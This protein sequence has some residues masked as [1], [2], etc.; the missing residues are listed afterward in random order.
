MGF[1]APGALIAGAALLLAVL[2]TYLLRPRRPTRPVSSTF[3]WLAALNDVQ[4][5]RPWRR[6]P[7][8]LLLLLQIAALAAMVAALARPY[9][10]SADST[11]PFSVVLIDASASMQATDTPPTRFDVARTRVAQMIDGVEAGKSLALVSL[12]A[13]PRVLAPPTSDRGLLHRALDTLQPTTQSANLAVALSIA[14]SVAEGHADAQVVVVA[15]GSL[16]RSQAPAT[17]P[18]PV[19]YVAVGSARAGNLSVAGLSTRVVDGNISALA[20]VANYGAQATTATLV[21][22]VDGAQFDSRALAIDPAS[23][24]DAQWDN[25]PATAHTLE[26]RIGEPDSLALDN[27]AWSV[28]GADR[29]TRVLLVSD[30][31]VFVERALGLRPNTQVTRVSPGDYAPRSQAFD[32]IVLDGFAPP[33]LP[34]GSSVLLLHPPL[35]NGLIASSGADVPISTVSAVRPEDPLLADV[36]L[37]GVHVSRARR[38]EAPGWADI[39]LASPETPLLLVGDQAG[40]RVGI[41]GFD[42]HQSDLPLQPGFPVLA[43]HLLDWLVPSSSTAT[44]IV[45]VGE[46]VAIAPLPEAVSVEVIAP[47]GRQVQVAPPLPPPAFNATD[48]PGLYQVVQRDPGGRETRSFFAVNFFNPRESQV[49]PGTESG[50]PAVGPRREPLKAPREIWE[51]FAVMALVFLAIEAGLAWWQFAAAALRARLALALRVTLAA[52]LILALM[53]VGVPQPVDRQATAFVADV[54]ASVQDAQPQVTTFLSSALAAKRPDD[55]YALVSAARGAAVE[56]GLST[57]VRSDAGQPIQ[58]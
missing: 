6:V 57:V 42:V 39:V 23:V 32:L 2:A 41:L 38:L 22:R 35:D 34:T 30:G 25:L 1:L 20:R 12:D 54:S 31:N 50:A 14:A 7:P 11:G 40:R 18:L 10:L 13:Q 19:R 4:A 21:L 51:A 44:P 28:V 16:D 37:S 52:L 36:P 58:A 45:Q 48:V 55:A 24:A 17:F 47:D 56:Q 5:Q 33:V 53:G 27:S 9:L 43:Q 29:P 8:S 26:A 3:L 15:D 49:A 46:S